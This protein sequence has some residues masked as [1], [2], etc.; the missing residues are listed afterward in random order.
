MST[1]GTTPVAPQHP[2]GT[3]SQRKGGHHVAW[4]ACP[5]FASDA[6]VALVSA[7]NPWR[8]ET[9]GY[10]L[11]EAVLYPLAFGPSALPGCTIQHILDAAHNVLDYPPRETQ[12][13]LRWIYT[14][15]GAYL[16]V[17]GAQWPAMAEATAPVVVEATPVP[18][19]APAA[20]PLQAIATTAKSKSRTVRAS[21]AK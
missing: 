21:K 5:R 20:T 19:A 15:G 4:V 12:G 10:R 1:T 11:W 18:E 13:H 17:G 7:T 3:G 14:W 6:S 2:A 16:A 8:R 9:P